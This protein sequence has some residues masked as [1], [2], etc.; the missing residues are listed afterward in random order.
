MFHG[1]L[2]TEVKIKASKLQSIMIVN[3]GKHLEEVVALRQARRESV[4]DA[5]EA[6]LEAMREDPEYQVSIQFVHEYPEINDHTEDYDLALRMV[7]LSEEK[8]ISL[9]QDQ[10]DKL[11]MDNWEWK[12]EMMFANTAYQHKL[13]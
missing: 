6:E 10:F 8:V 1:E 7:E 3:R 4:K 11:V 13:G 2:L 9:K 12:S 5:L